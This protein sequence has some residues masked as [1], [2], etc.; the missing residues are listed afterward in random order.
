[1][2]VNITIAIELHAIWTIHLV[3][4]FFL[5]LTTSVSTATSS[6]GPLSYNKG[7]EI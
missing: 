5:G 2:H 6:T 4:L 1:V 3:V 7:H